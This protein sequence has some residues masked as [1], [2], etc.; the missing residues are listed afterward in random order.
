MLVVCVTSARNPASGGTDQRY[1]ADGIFQ[2]SVMFVQ[3][4][5]QLNSDMS[6][7]AYSEAS[8]AESPLLHAGFFYCVNVKIDL[9][10]KLTLSLETFL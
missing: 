3:L 5:L 6:I 10:N 2:S 7:R 9:S 4:G 1:K 8:I